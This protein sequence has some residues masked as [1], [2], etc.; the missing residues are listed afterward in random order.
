MTKASASNLRDENRDL[1]FGS[2]V[3]RESRQ[4]LLN[5]DGSFNVQRT[6][7]NFITSLSLYHT[8]LTMSW[9]TFLLLVLLLY[10]LSNILFGLIYAFLG[11]EAIVDTSN[12]PTENLFLRG[13]F[14]S[15]QTFATIGYG[16][17]HPV[18]VIPNLLVTIESYYSM[19]VTALVTGIVFA[20]FS[21]PTARI[22]FS[23]NA[24]VAP[25][26]NGKGF[27]FRLVNMRSSQLIDV[28]AQVL[29][30]R[31]VEEDGV[32]TRQF[33]NL[34]LERRMVSFLPLAWTVV[35]SIDEASPL[36]G[37]THEDLEKSDAEI[38]ILLTAIDE[39]FAQ[40]VHTRTSYKPG[41]IV[42]NAK[43]VNLYNEMNA[44]EPISINIRKL[45]Q[46]EKVSRELHP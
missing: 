1:G 8:F 17:I 25:Y 7:L 30:S 10:F 24:V 32:I 29:F 35:H 37:L 42:W 6:G 18:G 39:G 33:D 28:S 5:P 11:A 40:T 15:V 43:F 3:A 20:R 16:T 22:K 41:E 14:F 2:V 36:Y 23:K 13:F 46:I 31:F 34:Q 9:A 38:L 4:R 26:Q 44:N 19:I 45:S 27:M 21:R 12:T